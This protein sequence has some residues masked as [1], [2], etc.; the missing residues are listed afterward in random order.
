MAFGAWI[1]DV[2]VAGVG[3]TPRAELAA[4]AGLVMDDGVVVD[5]RHRTSA[6][7]LF[8]A[9]DVA[10][11]AGRRVEHWHAAREGGAAAAMAMLDEPPPEP[12]APWVFSEF[13]GASLD[14]VGWAPTWDE[15]VALA[16]GRVVAYLV[17][18]AVAQL[19]IIDS[20]LLVDSAREFVE[21]SG[22]RAELDAVLSR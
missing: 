19:A 4:G 1:A 5:E 6:P 3:V 13:A 22:S 14:V 12:R 8:A 15:A 7:G 10:R 9:G 11:V 16:G 21:R 2:L 18:G 17:E 20:A